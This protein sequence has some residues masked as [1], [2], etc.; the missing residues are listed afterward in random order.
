MKYS[1]LT[2]MAIGDVLIIKF[3][4]ED[5]SN[6]KKW[7]D[8]QTETRGFT[9]FATKYLYDKYRINL[10]KCDWMVTE[11]HPCIRTK[12]CEIAIQQLSAR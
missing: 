12:N 8:E 3:D 11:A 6:Y 4:D 10:S 2:L 5:K 7:L 1:F 9:D